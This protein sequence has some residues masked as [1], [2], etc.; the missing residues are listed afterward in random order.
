MTITLLI[1]KYNYTRMNL[2][3]VQGFGDLIKGTIAVLR[4]QISTCPS[5]SLH[6]IYIAAQDG[7][8]PTNQPR[9]K[10][11]FVVEGRSCIISVF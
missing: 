2:G 4:R 3:A 5:T 1:V 6:S 10:L 11:L 7:L 9:I 8:Q